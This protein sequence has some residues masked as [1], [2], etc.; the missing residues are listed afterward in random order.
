MVG[1]ANHK[2]W[3]LRRLKIL[4]ASHETL[5]DI[6]KLFVR[7]GLLLASPLWSSALSRMNQ[8]QLERIQRQATRVIIGP[9][10]LDYDQRMALLSLPSLERHRA[11]LTRKF[12]IKMA[13]DPKFAHLFPKREGP[14]TRSKLTY[15]QPKCNTNRYKTSS[16][17]SF[18]T[19]L[20]KEANKV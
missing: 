20:N 7:Q 16:L 13:A 5:V 6:Y 4:G 12:A 15:I 9:L 14:D 1:T 2:L 17:P 3:F 19:I 8:N 10:P 11:Q 18:I